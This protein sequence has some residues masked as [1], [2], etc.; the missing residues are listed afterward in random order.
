MYGNESKELEIILEQTRIIANLTHKDRGPHKVVLSLITFINQS[1]FQIMAL[2][3]GATQKAQGTLGLTDTVT[4]LPVV[5][6][7]FASVTATPDSAFFTA[8]VNPDNSITVSG[9]SPGSGNLNVSASATFKDS[10]GATQ[11]QTLTVAIP[12]TV[13]QATADSVALTV[14]FGT[15]A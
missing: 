3:L 13:A 15:P 9:A 2:T 12:V 14:T 6:S 5:A 11:T 10:T 4:N 7:S 8:V 1:K